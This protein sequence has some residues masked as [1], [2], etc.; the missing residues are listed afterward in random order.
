M[1]PWIGQ[2]GEPSQPSSRVPN[3]HEYPALSRP[4]RIS[5]ISVFH[6]VSL[7][8]SFPSLYFRN[9]V[10]IKK[11]ELTQD[12]WVVSI[13]FCCLQGNQLSAVVSASP[14]ILYS[15][16]AVRNQCFVS[17][18]YAQPTFQQG[19]LAVCRAMTWRGRTAC[20]VWS[21]PRGRF[22]AAAQ[23][24][25]EVIPLLQR[26]WAFLYNSLWGCRNI[27]IFSLKHISELL[28]VCFYF[29]QIH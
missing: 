5:P 18:L 19:E 17:F 28:S 12:S 11:N 25:C 6:C 9:M 27:N 1:S 2:I 24:G 26:L 22:C 21:V 20:G 16:I 23:P 14:S 4:S 13:R 8:L 15:K 29:F 7:P 10:W 3:S